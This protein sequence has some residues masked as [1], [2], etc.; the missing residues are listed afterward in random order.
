[1]K[2]KNE[3]L[4]FFMVV[5]H[6]GMCRLTSLKHNKHYIVVIFDVNCIHFQ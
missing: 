1:M 6:V 3:L 4:L 5:L 2:N